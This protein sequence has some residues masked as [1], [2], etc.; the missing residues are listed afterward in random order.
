MKKK[1]QE[2]IETLL[3]AFIALAVAAVA[4]L[5]YD[6][7]NEMRKTKAEETKPIVFISPEMKEKTYEEVFGVDPETEFVP[8]YY[9]DQFIWFWDEDIP[10]SGEEQMYLQIACRARHICPELVLAIMERESGYDKNAVNS[11]CKGI[12]QIN[13]AVHDI[14]NPFNYEQSVDVGVA[15]LEELFEKYED[16]GLVMM[17]WHGESD[18]V[19]KYESGELSKYADGILARSEIL[20]RKHGK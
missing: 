6:A 17:K 13:T 11:T 10:L 1:R 4:A 9:D 12:L 3:F 15:Y 16:V 18:A 20:E 7:V 19:E 8:G 5:I 14:E 2:L